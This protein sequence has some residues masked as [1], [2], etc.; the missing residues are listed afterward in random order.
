MALPDIKQE[1]AF[2][3]FP[4]QQEAK[5]AV[6]TWFND[7]ERSQV[8]RLFG[9]AG[10]GKTTITKSIIVDIRKYLT[11]NEIDG[12]ILS[13]AY[14][15][16]ATRVMR[17]AGMPGARTLHS[18]IYKP[19]LPNKAFYKELKAKEAKM[20]EDK[21]PKADLAAIRKQKIECQ[22]IVFVLNDESE[23]HGCALLV[24]DECSMVNEEM[25]NDL[26]SFG[27]PILVLG[28]PGQLPPIHGTGA[29][30]QTKPD[31]M[32]DK[33]HRQ[34]LDNPIIALSFK[35]RTKAR[36]TPGP[37][38]ESQVSQAR[39]LTNGQIKEADQILVGK[40][41]TRRIWNQRV[42]HILGFTSPYPEPGEKLICLRNYAKNG[43]FNGMMVTV[44]RLIEE[45]DV[46]T[47]MA[48]R[49]E[50]DKEII[51]NANRAYFDEY[52][53]PGTLK[54]LD[55]W[56][57]QGNHEFDYGYAITVHK[58]QGSQWD[59]VIFYDDRFLSWDKDNR[60]KWL[61][62]GITRAAERIT[63]VQ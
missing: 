22:K 49:D 25:A 30:I 10:T 62:T 61:Y 59:H 45:F 28:D 55:W 42:R 2:T 37:Y 41:K 33:I 39:M 14:T 5:D 44:D 7:P 32:L 29:L 26:Y 40:N 20:V 47:K 15:G 27:M 38:G 36:I 50:D 56:H 51:I 24:V 9:Y 11:E 21:A 35:A 1:P 52:K 46:Y 34:A 13:G 16:K 53:V 43:L 18:L 3:L 63:L 4:E 12:P 19:E 23:L 57:F 58:S 31:I 6:L 54:S 17:R 48:V 60:A 8:F